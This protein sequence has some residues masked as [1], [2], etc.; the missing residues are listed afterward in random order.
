MPVIIEVTIED[1]QLEGHD[2]SAQR[3]EAYL[4]S[5]VQ[6]ASGMIISADVLLDSNNVLVRDSKGE[7]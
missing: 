5:A 4:H 7:F 6:T 2:F 3:L 1:S